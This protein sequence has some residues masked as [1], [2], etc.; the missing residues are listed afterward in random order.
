MNRA[1]ESE[2]SK[3]G[4]YGKMYVSV[5]LSLSDKTPPSSASARSGMA[6]VRTQLKTHVRSAD[7]QKKNGILQ[8]IFKRCVCNIKLAALTVSGLS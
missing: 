8:S 2:Y 1:N 4:E 3:T 6:S 5:N 7:V